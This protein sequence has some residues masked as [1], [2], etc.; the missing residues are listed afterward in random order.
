M[1]GFRYYG[2]VNAFMVAVLA[3]SGCGQQAAQQSEVQVNTYKLAA[4]DAQIPTSFNGTV[5]AENKTAIH[6]RVSGHVVESML[7]AGN[8]LQRGNRCIAWTLVNTKLT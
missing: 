5:T 3:L 6:A 2:M 7:R 1:K 8:M 4:S